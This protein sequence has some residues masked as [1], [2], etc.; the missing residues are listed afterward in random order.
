MA[1][2]LKRLLKAVHDAVGLFGVSVAAGSTVEVYANATVNQTTIVKELTICNPSSTDARISIAIKAAADAMDRSKCFF[3][4]AHILAGQTAIVS[5]SSVVESGKGLF[6]KATGAALNVHAE[7][8]ELMNSSAKQLACILAA[9]TLQTIYTAPANKSNQMYQLLAVN[10]DAADATLTV[11]I[12]PSNGVND[13]RNTI[14]HNVTLKPNE[15]M[16]YTTKLPLPSGYR[17]VARASKANVI[18]VVID[19]TEK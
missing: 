12:V 2:S 3:Y 5:L 13:A 18:N 11:Q 14:L 6:I 4:D 8:V 17:I 10:T 1:A 16:M 9:N 19:G 7:G 15:T